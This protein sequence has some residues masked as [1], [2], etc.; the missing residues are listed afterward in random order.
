M[1]PALAVPAVEAP[2][3]GWTEFSAGRP[4]GEPAWLVALRDTAAARFRE[5]G[6]PS[7]RDEDWRQTPIGPIARTRFVPAP[8]VSDV[9]APALARLGFD[10]AFRGR[11]IVLV[12]GR[13]APALS[14]LDRLQGVRVEPL[15]ALLAR[16]PG[17]LE[18]HLSAV[19]GIDG[20]FAALNTSFL[21]DGAAVLIPASSASAEPIHVLLDGRIVKSGGKELA[22]EL[23]SR[24]YEW[25]DRRVAART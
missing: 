13:V 11:E 2:D 6:L 22:V 12:N 19:A 23:E 25:L 24:G 17:L 1:A 4:A 15:A 16:E 21:A 10:G 20:A 3:F 9:P 8:P 18:P 14:S 7:V 5:I